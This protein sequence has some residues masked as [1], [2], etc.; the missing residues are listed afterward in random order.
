MKNKNYKIDIEIYII[1][2]IVIGVTVFNAI[3]SSINISKNQEVTSQIVNVDI[4]T[5]QQLQNM[6]LLVTRSKMYATNWVYLPGNKADKD[7]LHKIHSERYPLLKG[8]ISALMSQWEDK[9][10]VDSMYVV[11]HEFNDLVKWEKKIMEE[12]GNFD[13]YEDPTRKFTAAEILE[14]EILPRSTR[15]IS[16]LD[17][18]ISSKKEQ[19]GVENILMNSS[20]K[21]LL[22]SVSGIA[23]MIIVVVL[24]AI[25]YM[26]NSIIV[27]LVRLKNYVVQMGKGEVPEIK[28]HTGKGAVGQMTSALKD[29][30]EALKQT[31][32]F[33]N[34]IGEGNFEVNFQPLS[35]NDE[36]GNA[37][38]QM[39]DSLQKAEQETRFR[40]WT[41][42]GL[43]RIGE[44]LREN[45]DDIEKLSEAIIHELVKFFEVNQG[46]IFLVR[47]NQ[48][49]EDYIE[50]AGAYAI[51]A[52]YKENKRLRM[53]EGLIGQCINDQETIQLKN[54]PNEFFSISSGLGTAHASNIL[55][56]PLC[57]N[58][59]V[60]GAIELACFREF[61]E[62]EV[63][64]IEKIGDAMASSIASSIANSV[65][66][67]L[68]EET[69]KQAD[70]LA[71][72]EEELLRTNEELSKQSLR[73]KASETDLRERNEDLKE[74]ARLMKEKNEA[75]EMAREALSIKAKELELNSR[76]KSE[77][78]ANMSHELRTPLNSVLI[79]AR[80]LSENKNR[81]LSE[82]EIEYANVIHKSGNDLLM[83]I[84]DILDLS[85]IEAGK[86]ELQ[87]EQTSL[88][89]IKN[90]IQ[91]MFREVANDKKIDFI[92]EMENS[93][94]EKI[95]TDKMRLEQVIKNL[96]SNAFKFTKKEN[97]FVKISITS[98][99]KGAS[100]T[101]KN[102]LTSRHVIGIAVS[103]NGIGIS[104]DKQKLIFEAFKQ[105]DGS[106][107]RK[108]G[109]TGLGLSI[110]RELGQLLGGEIHVESKEGEGS[111]FTL[112]IP[113]EGNSKNEGT[114]RAS[115]ENSTGRQMS[116]TAEEKYTLQG[117]RSIVTELPDDR[118]NIYASEKV[119]LIIEDDLA[120]AKILYDFAHENNFKAVIATQGDIGLAYA[121]QYKPHAILLDMQLPVIDGWTVLKKL[122]ENEVLKQI[123]VHVMSVMDKKKLG[124]EMG[125]LTYLKKPVDKKDL[126]NSFKAI[127][128]AYEKEIR[129]VLVVEDDPIQFELIKTLIQSKEKNAK[130]IHAREALEAYSL[131]AEIKFDCI[132]LDI[133]L[134]SDSIS[135]FR[136][137]EK[138][139]SDGQLTDTPVIVYTG[140]DV[141]P[142]Q[143]ELLKKHSSSLIMKSPESLPKLLEKTAS[144]LHQ[145]RENTLS[146]N[147]K[148][149]E[150]LS[151][152]CTLLVDDDMRNIYAISGVLESEGLNV[153]I[154]NN[155]KEALDRLAQY[156]NIDIVLMDIMMPEMDGY[157]AMKEIRKM[158]KYRDLPIIAV[159]AKAMAGDREKCISAG[160]S[161]Y[162]AKPVN[163]DQ[164]LSLMKVYL[165]TEV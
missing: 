148:T 106:T 61:K 142:E 86:F 110:S 129:K 55:I 15:I 164:L 73:L 25:F 90:D 96:L 3:Y 107:S 78:L 52:R 36:F 113:E 157:T 31:A 33:A 161:D 13:D 50:L 30:T 1:F 105:A 12:L 93:L 60:Y 62:N 21:N 20:Y 65:T 152:K 99:T 100:F 57:N 162:I 128:D 132:I 118:N 6:N 82:K 92:I 22:W 91:S 29:L 138:I 80:L 124:I 76:Y 104:P 144:F 70:R 103:D 115:E 121:T 147:P 150:T 109:G 130:C 85:K 27:P 32:N 64:F 71:S 72:Q 63:R 2:L 66:R 98:A 122:K 69:K 59:E 131:L 97:G 19:A 139:K 143:E 74:T 83:L 119:I 45:T 26:T 165:Y 48:R 43:T 17:Y 136:F 116:S 155:G 42:N 38:L 34:E 56:V 10:N 24:F 47:K 41:N 137:L 40:N 75:L 95:N 108:Y 8:E 68:L 37:L 101:N 16:S 35:D 123:P 160:A 127:S 49:G 81:T 77:F 149:T 84:N 120:F 54:I 89:E 67:Q 163:V 145:I 39:R 114:D 94:P 135:G 141:Y 151:G 46:G 88:E 53:G 9:K 112:Y 44:V 11:F 159:T 28:V 156:P 79:L 158:E 87:F 146:T 23:I 14:N 18:V 153:I 133:N 58:G 125:A 126:D 102:L 111:T 154:A 5:V 117:S 7:S 134:G 4:P 140:S 51:D